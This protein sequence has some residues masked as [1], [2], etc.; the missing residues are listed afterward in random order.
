ME[1]SYRH[2]GMRRKLIQQLRERGIKDESVLDAM[3]RLPR[4]FFLEKAFEEWAYEDKAFP[5]G[6]EQTISQ[7]YTV[8]YQSSLLKIAQGDQVLEVGTGSG[9][10]AAILALMGAVVFSVER[11][12]ALYQ[13]ASQLLTD[14]QL[15]N[16]H[17]FHHDGT[18]GLA[19]FAPYD[20]ILVTAGAD[21][22]PL[23]LIEQLK[24]G[25]LLVV[26]IGDSHIQKM[27]SIR[28]ISASDW[29]EE[30]WD[31]FRFVPLLEGKK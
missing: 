3:G 23:A 18:R 12:L 30:R 1:D 22:M 9:Y 8:A 10:Q 15:P 5:I 24:I 29:Q 7:P 6:L 28:K 14:L 13:K 31:D 16:I 2:K 27:C 26:P 21:E 25:G 19:D 17:T 20:K 4:H 11:H